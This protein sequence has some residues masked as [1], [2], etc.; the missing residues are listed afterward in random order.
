MATRDLNAHQQVFAL[1]LMANIIRKNKGVIDDL[2]KQ[3]EQQLP[4]ALQLLGGDWKVT[5]GP[6]VWKYKPCD[7]NTGPDHVWFVARSPNLRFPDG[8]EKDTYVLAV[9]GTATDY[10]WVA[11][12]ARVDKVVNFYTWLKA[13]LT[14]PPTG[15][16]STSPENC[17]IAYGTALGVY[18]LVDFPSPAASPRVTLPSYWAG[19]PDSPNTKVVLTGH[20]LGGALS[21]S[22][23]FGL[24]ESGAFSK[25]A[26]NNILVY[27]TAGPT[28]GN[29]VFSQLFSK[30][31]PKVPGPGYQVWNSN[32]VNAL[33][34]VSQAWCI[35]RDASPAQNMGNIPT[36]YGSPAIWS[37]K[38]SVAVAE[39]WASASGSLYIPIQAAR[40]KGTAPTSRP[41][42][43]KNFLKEAKKQHVEEF[44]KT[45][46]IPIPPI[47]ILTGEVDGIEQMTEEEEDS[48]EPVLQDLV[49]QI[50]KERLAA[51]TGSAAEQYQSIENLSHEFTV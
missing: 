22:L 16:I 25:F 27:P 11:N 47:K 12:N 32:I 3:I 41:E 19:F 8:Q 42:T 29:L 44:I 18:H 51:E 38:V 23:A 48:L 46:D 17:Y 2:Q 5:W 35:S 14:T 6:V 31:F 36:I 49:N 9:A 20:S 40:F 13:G 50:R 34:I 7:K 15:E 43:L 39:A 1:S 28:P 37:V 21:P 30:K 24:L 33:D 4:L 26:P 45:F 10:N